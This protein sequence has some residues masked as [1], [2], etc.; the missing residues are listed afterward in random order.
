VISGRAARTNFSREEPSR[1]PNVFRHGLLPHRVAHPKPEKRTLGITAL[2]LGKRRDEKPKRKEIEAHGS[3]DEEN[4]SSKLKRWAVYRNLSSDEVALQHPSLAERK[5]T[6]QFP[7]ENSFWSPFVEVTS[8]QGRHCHGR[9][10]HWCEDRWQRSRVGREAV[11]DSGD[12]RRRRACRTRQRDRDWSRHQGQAVARRH[13]AGP[14]E[15]K[16]SVKE[17]LQHGKGHGRGRGTDRADRRAGAVG[18][19]GHRRKTECSPQVAD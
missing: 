1:R 14:H 17:A 4:V 7:L 6:A 5:R 12:S 9:N 19:R 16:G 10:G 11:Q 3:A 2:V 13:V 15:R 18:K 8:E